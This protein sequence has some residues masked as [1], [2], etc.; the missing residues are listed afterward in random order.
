MVTKKRKKIEEEMAKQTKV[1]LDIKIHA[2][3]I[4]IAEDLSQKDPLLLVAN[5]GVL[6]INT[7]VLFYF[8]Y[9]GF[10]YLSH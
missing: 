7:D 3:N 10:N 1:E 4:I 8:E 9:F 6:Y 2:P 5:F